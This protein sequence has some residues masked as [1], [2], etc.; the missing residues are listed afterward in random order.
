MGY[1]KPNENTPKDYI[2]GNPDY[3]L[4]ESGKITTTPNLDINPTKRRREDSSDEETK[5][6]VKV[7][8]TEVKEGVKDEEDDSVKTVKKK[9][10]IKKEAAAN[11]EGGKTTDSA[12]ADI[13]IHASTSLTQ[14]MA[15][16]TLTE[17]TE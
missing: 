17:G 12:A 6:V 3:S 7:E 9:K 11:D 14:E 10:R 15:T 16:T 8:K 5:P 2:D 13:S 1:G 4:V